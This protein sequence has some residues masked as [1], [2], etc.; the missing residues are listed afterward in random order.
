MILWFPFIFEKKIFKVIC[1]F[2][3]G[4]DDRRMMLDGVF[5][6][7]SENQRALPFNVKINEI[8]EEMKVFRGSSS[9]YSANES[10]HFRK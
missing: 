7:H 6:Y 4:Y 9:K 3:V 1:L 5:S 10:R 8:S 2:S